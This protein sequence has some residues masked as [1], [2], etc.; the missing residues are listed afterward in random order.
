M[1]VV[2]HRGILRIPH[3]IDAFLFGAVDHFTFILAEVTALFRTAPMT[4]PYIR[5]RAINVCNGFQPLRFIFR[6]TD[7]QRTGRTEQPAN[8]GEFFIRGGIIFVVIIS[9][10]I[11]HY[12]HML[13]GPILFGHYHTVPP[14]L[15]QVFR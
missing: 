5:R 8:G 11:A 2:H 9:P 4:F 14:P 13:S 7:K 12:I 6:R 10:K 15:T 3:K 1:R